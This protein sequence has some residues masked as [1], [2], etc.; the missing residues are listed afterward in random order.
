[1]CNAAYHTALHLR[2]F[3]TFTCPHVSG[4]TEAER[5]V[6]AVQKMLAGETGN[7]IQLSLSH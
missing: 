4:N 2:E 7:A 1:M 5:F 3:E 6:N